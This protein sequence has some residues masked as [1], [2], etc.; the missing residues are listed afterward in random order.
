MSTYQH[1]HTDACARLQTCTA[2]YWHSNLCCCCYH[3]CCRAY[4]RELQPYFTGTP[5]SEELHWDDSKVVDGP[6]DQFASN[7][8]L[9][10]LK[11]TFDMALYTTV[12]DPSNL[13]D[14]M[15]QEKAAIIAQEIERGAY[16]FPGRAAAHLA[17]ERGQEVEDSVSGGW[18]YLLH[19]PGH[20]PCCAPK[21]LP[22][23]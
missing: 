15:T 17:E 1:V 18:G 12:L 9:T 22:G 14:S 4:G 6:W 7:E 19:T 8:R 5:D 10:G 13:R 3:A 20:C 23:P 11:T 16:A 2:R 21:A